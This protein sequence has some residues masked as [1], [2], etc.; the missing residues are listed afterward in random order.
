MIDQTV[1]TRCN[2]CS[3]PIIFHTALRTSLHSFFC[4]LCGMP[5]TFTLAPIKRRVG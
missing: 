5:A 4:W 2:W 3:H 1:S